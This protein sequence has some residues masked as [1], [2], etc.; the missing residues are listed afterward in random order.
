MKDNINTNPRGMYLQDRRWMKLSQ[1]RVKW[2]SF[3]LAK[4]STTRELVTYVQD[5]HIIL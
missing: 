1:S 2:G 4:V 5:V 3:V